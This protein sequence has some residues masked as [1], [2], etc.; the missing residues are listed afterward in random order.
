MKPR[1]GFT[2]IELLVVIAIIA[3]LLSVIIPSLKNAREYAKR[4]I[5]QSNLRQ[6][7]VT[8]G[9]Y[10]S[11]FA[12]N[13]RGNTKWYFENGTGDLPWEWQPYGIE[14][15]MDNRMLPDRKVFFCPAVRN[16]SHKK[17]YLYGQVIVGNMQSYDT[18]AIEYR[19]ETESGFTDRPVFWG[20]YSW[21]WKKGADDRSDGATLS[22]NNKISNNVLLCDIPDQVYQYAM[23]IGNT[24]A[25]VLTKIFGGVGET[26]QT[27]PHGNALLSDLSVKNPANKVEEFNMWLW[28][29][30]EWAGMH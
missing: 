8:I 6:L 7:G 14:N 29:D 10:E 23:G 3:L 25:Q 19:M 1:K 20:T 11:Q 17:N 27:I 4:V 24:D 5:C 18:G 30:T 13:F 16:V 21:L 9:N 12:F 26:V 28:N 22:T 15:L 2:L